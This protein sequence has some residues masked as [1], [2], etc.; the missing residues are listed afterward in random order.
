MPTCA[1]AVVGGGIVGL[2]TAREWLM[3]FPGSSVAVIEKEPQLAA[4]QTGHN[5][6][7]IHSGIYYRP[8]SLKAQTCAIGARLMVEFCETHH[9][10]YEICGKVIVATGPSELPRLRA[11]YERGLANGV[12][13]VAMIGPERLREIE[14]HASGIQA[15]HVPQAG[16]VD[17]P[18]VARVIAGLIRRE[19][20]QIITSARVQHLRRDGGAWLL[21]TTRGP[22][23]ATRVVT[24]GGLYADRLAAMAGAPDDLRIAP[25]RGEYYELIPERRFLVKAMIYPVPEP[26][27]PFLGAHLTRSI[28]GRVHAGP[29]AVLALKREGYR[30]TDVSLTDT[31]QL[32]G[33]GGFWK[34]ARKYWAVGLAELR[35]SFSARGFVRDLQRLVPEIRVE[36]VTVG[37]HGVRAQALDPRGTLLDDFNI[38]RSDGA[39]HVRNVPSP[40]ATASLRVAQLIVDMAAEACGGASGSLVSGRNS[41]TSAVKNS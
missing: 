21:D 7:V 12:P 18:S 2:S 4:H 38:I 24:C 1:L 27:L 20:G 40:A 41:L 8:G 30:N 33:Y 32:L 34:M 5:S 17:Y 3:R 26:S 36:D 39:I 31:L 11:L 6:G 35:R 19:G 37:V 23:R 16:I 9:I 10:P 15:L 29:N 25:F 22:I 14:P 13:G 28:T